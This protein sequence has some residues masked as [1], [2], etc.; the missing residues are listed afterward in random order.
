MYISSL[1]TG[2]IEVYNRITIN[3]Y[4]VGCLRDCEGCSNEIYKDFNFPNRVEL[5][6]ERLINDLEKSSELVD[7]VCWLGGDAIY[8]KDSLINLSHAIRE[9][10][11]NM[12]NC[13]YTGEL[14][15]NIDEE[16]LSC[17]INMI[18]D[19]PWRGKTI[20][21]KDTNQRIFIKDDNNWSQVSY[22]ELIKRMEK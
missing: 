10:N 16:V 21:E 12:V 11:P 19:G 5:T 1:S 3:I 8:Q 7:G 9:F 6:K 15:E 18:V 4:P 17:G 20:H 14:F 2:F 13:L 22:D